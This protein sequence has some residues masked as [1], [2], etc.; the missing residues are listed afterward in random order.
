MRKSGRLI[1]R[2][3]VNVMQRTRHVVQRKGTTAKICTFSDAG[4]AYKRQATEEEKAAVI[5]I[6]QIYDRGAL[7]IIDM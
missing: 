4:Q 7:N 3:Y 1:N 2:R 6:T 5:E